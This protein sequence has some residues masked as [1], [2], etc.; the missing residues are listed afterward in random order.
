MNFDEAQ[1]RRLDITLLLVFEE[2]MAT[3]K[4]SAAARRLGLTQS[5]IS[6]ALK[7]LRDVFGDELFIRTPRGVQ[8]TP[9]TL[10]LRA[11]LAEALRLI[12]GAVR[13][14]GFDPERDGRV[15]R[16]AASDYETSLFAPALLGEGLG[17]A[18]FIF[19]TLVR[20]EAIEA[21]HAGDIDLLLGYAWDKG[22][23]CEA[24]TL[25]HED[26]RVVARRGHPALSEPLSLDRFTR[27]GHVLVSPGGML[28]G[29]VDKALKDAGTSRQVVVAVP[30]FLAA[31]ATVART[32]LLATVPRRVAH[33]H[34]AEF[35]LT[36]ALPPVPVRSFPVQMIWIR[37][38]GMDPALSWLRN[39]IQEVSGHMA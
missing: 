27:F 19:R 39:R 22:T 14:P 5:A 13:P 36:T 37:R 8:P 17:D 29:I 6:H 32:D 33:C 20:R 25:F 1:L 12:G 35:G 3:G 10:A 16:V 34:A 26:Y 18:R 9:R 23:G 38:L 2:A 15:F 24:V 28:T 11:P 7:R 4:L 21:M 31:L 30:Y